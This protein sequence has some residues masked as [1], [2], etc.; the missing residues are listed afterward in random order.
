MQKI[1][2]DYTGQIKK[3]KKR[4]WGNRLESYVERFHVILK[5]GKPKRIIRC[6]EPTVCPESGPDVKCIQT[7]EEM[8]EFPKKIKST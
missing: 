1:K 3:K 6:C 2:K 5:R 7:P 8:I 4:C